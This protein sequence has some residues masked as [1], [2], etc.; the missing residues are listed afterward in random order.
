MVAT[1][2]NDELV[3]LVHAACFAALLLRRRWSRPLSATL[4]FGWAAL[5][6]VQL[7]EHFRRGS[8]DTTGLLIAV[9]LMVSLLLFGSYLVLS[10]KARSFLGD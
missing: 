7:T 1:P 5:L 3:W 4:A 10:S 9:T 6:G 8:S 2:E